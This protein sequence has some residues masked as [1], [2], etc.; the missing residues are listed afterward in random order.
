MQQKVDFIFSANLDRDNARCGFLVPR[1][2]LVA[3]EKNLHKPHSH[4]K[5]AHESLLEPLASGAQDRFVDL[6]SATATADLGV[7]E[8]SAFKKTFDHQSVSAYPAT[9]LAEGERGMGDSRC[10]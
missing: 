9:K 5:R 4:L 1:H 2:Q 6:P 7:G 8:H 3:W 10:V